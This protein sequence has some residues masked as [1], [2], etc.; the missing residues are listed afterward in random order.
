MVQFHYMAY[1]ATQRTPAPWGHEFS[2]FN[3]PFLG[4]H[5]YILTLSV[6][7][8]GEEEKIFKKNYA[9]SLYDLYGHAPAK[10]PLPRGS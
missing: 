3:R 1:M 7:C 9:I 5:N 8:M 2:N 6:L 10:G 4:H